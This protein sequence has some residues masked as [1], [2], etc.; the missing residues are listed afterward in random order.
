VNCGAYSAASVY[1]QEERETVEWREVSYRILVSIIPAIRFMALI[2][3]IAPRESSPLVGS[4]FQDQTLGGQI[5]QKLDRAELLRT[6]KKNDT[7]RASKLA[8]NRQ[9]LSLLKR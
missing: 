9:P 5:Q 7:W 1:K 8:S 2:T 6:V 4:A 3:T